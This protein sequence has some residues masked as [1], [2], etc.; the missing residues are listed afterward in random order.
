MVVESLQNNRPGSDQSKQVLT[1]V[2]CYVVILLAMLCTLSWLVWNKGNIIL[3]FV[4][5]AIW[6]WS[7]AG[8]MVAV[9]YRLASPRFTKPAGLQLY[10]WAVGRPITG[11]FLGA[12]VYFVA[13]AG[14]KLVDADPNHLKDALWLN[15]IAFFG[16]FKEEL[17]IRAAASFFGAKVADRTDENLV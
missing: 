4:P 10:A 12:T 16:G 1:L 11:L 9:I 2:V 7:F 3:M 8:S 14:V 5:V 15:V 6:E 17:S 13:L